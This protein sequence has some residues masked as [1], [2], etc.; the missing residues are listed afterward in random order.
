M[1]RLLFIIVL[2][3]SAA[4]AGAQTDL[5]INEL[6]DGEFV[7][8][9]RA[10]EIVQQGGSLNDYKLSQYHS[11]TVKGAPELAQRFETLLRADGR[12]ATDREITYRNGGIYFAFYQL[13][14]ADK[15]NRYIFYLNAHRA[16]GNK[17]MLI[18]MA[19]KASASEIKSFMNIIDSKK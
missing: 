1:K 11:L 13:P 7:D 18:Y 3:M 14:P 8:D 17:I 5:R 16:S 2:L 9:P 10:T 15:L 6:F 19:G 4:T 12:N